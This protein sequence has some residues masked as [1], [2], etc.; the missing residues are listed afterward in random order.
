MLFMEQYGRD[1]LWDDA[2]RIPTAN[3]FYYLKGDQYDALQ[4]QGE[5]GF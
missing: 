3:Q 5:A 2:S 1:P 4:C